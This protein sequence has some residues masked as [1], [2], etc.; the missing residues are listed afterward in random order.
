MYNIDVDHIHNVADL[1]DIVREVKIT[2]DG[3]L[4]NRVII[5]AVI[6]GLACYMTL[7]PKNEGIK[8]IIAVSS[9]G[10]SLFLINLVVAINDVRTANQD[11]RDLEARRTVLMRK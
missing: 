11:L 10:G 8:G 5:A 1:N 7:T 9:I 6:I 3:D 2:K 4:F